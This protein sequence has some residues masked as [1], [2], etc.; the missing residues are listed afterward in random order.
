MSMKRSIAGLA[1]VVLASSLALASHK[2]AVLD[3]TS[4]KVDVEPDSMA[5]EKGEKSFKENLT[6]AEGRV[7]MSECKKVGFDASDYSLS[8]DGEKN[9]T[10]KAEQE[11]DSQGTTIWTG[12]V[13][14]NLMHGKMIWTKKDGTV[15]TYDFHG[16]KLD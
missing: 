1:V 6:F 5:K 13:H 9:W 3:G 11:S 10:F 12:N 14:G 15:L 2:V 4:W 7:S 8:K 16:E